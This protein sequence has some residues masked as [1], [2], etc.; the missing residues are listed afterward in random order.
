[1]T[2]EPR[3]NGQKRRPVS[4][5]AP[6]LSAPEAALYPPLVP[7]IDAQ[8]RCSC[9][10]DQAPVSVSAGTSAPRTSPGLNNSQSAG[11]SLSLSGSHPGACRKGVDRGKETTVPPA[12][13]WT[14]RAKKGGKD[15]EAHMHTQGRR[16][17]VSV[18]EKLRDSSGVT[19][20]ASWQHL[21][22]AVLIPAGRS[23]T[24]SLG[25]DPWDYRT[26]DCS[27]VKRTGLPQTSF[28]ALQSHRSECS[29]RR[30]RSW[31]KGYPW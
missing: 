16:P 17:P 2:K 20:L 30:D 28:E 5:V 14:W 19:Q 29:Q 6:A 21:R 13:R 8:G 24:P 10:R 15:P 7:K 4:K 25:S 1:M 18:I 9:H 23:H 27:L 12:S 11:G 31:S 22:A 26:W 3:A